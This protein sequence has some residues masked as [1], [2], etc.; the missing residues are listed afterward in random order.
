MIIQKIKRNAIKCKT[1]GD[2]IESKYTHN[3]VVCSCQSCSV[4]GGLSYLKRS[5]PSPVAFEE[6]SEVEDV[7]VEE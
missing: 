1:C 2:I 3:F 4:D 6:L 5:A 7:E